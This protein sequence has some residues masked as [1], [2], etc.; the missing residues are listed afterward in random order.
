[1]NEQCIVY[2]NIFMV[3]GCNG[4]GKVHLLGKNLDNCLVSDGV[5]EQA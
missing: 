4:G 1:M 2:F 5:C 3:K